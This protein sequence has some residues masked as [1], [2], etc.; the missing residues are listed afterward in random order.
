MFRI[1]VSGTA[2]ITDSKP[3]FELSHFV[4]LQVEF[5]N[6]HLLGCR[7]GSRARFGYTSQITKVT[8]QREKNRGLYLN[9]V[10]HWDTRVNQEVV[11]GGKM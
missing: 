3:F 4:R 1:R 8:K 9:V 2:T 5:H 6:S 10:S 7:A 11:Y